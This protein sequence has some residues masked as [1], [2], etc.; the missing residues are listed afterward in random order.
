MVI[1]LHIFSWVLRR[2]RLFLLASKTQEAAY[3]PSC[4]SCMFSF[5]LAELQVGFCYLLKHL[6][7][8]AALV[9]RNVQGK[10]HLDWCSTSEKP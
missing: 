3:I 5:M 2:R 8:Q 10:K 7:F 1:V 9:L 6:M 4:C